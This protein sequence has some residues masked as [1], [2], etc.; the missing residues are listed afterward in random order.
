MNTTNL[1]ADT[2][3]WDELKNPKLKDEL[4]G[5]DG[6]VCKR[7]VVQSIETPA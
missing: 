2:A 6:R 4:Q 3:E 5:S 1:Q 7:V